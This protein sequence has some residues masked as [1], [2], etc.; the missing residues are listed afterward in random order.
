[1]PYIVMAMCTFKELIV[2]DFVLILL[3]LSFKVGRTGGILILQT[4]KLGLKEVKGLVQGHRY[5]CRMQI[6]CHQFRYSFGHIYTLWWSLAP[7]TQCHHPAETS[8]GVLHPSP[9]RFITSNCHSLFYYQKTQL[10]RKTSE[11][12]QSSLRAELASE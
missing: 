9:G 7:D 6:A 5:R 8:D 10:F 4:R 3:M 11:N 12:E 1:M 2:L